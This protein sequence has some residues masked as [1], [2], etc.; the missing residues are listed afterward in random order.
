M[1][2]YF[3][4]TFGKFDRIEVEAAGGGSDWLDIVMHVG[5]DVSTVRITLRSEEA[6]RDLHYTLGRYLAELERTR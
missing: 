6:V 3:Y 5:H 2:P 4:K 1:A